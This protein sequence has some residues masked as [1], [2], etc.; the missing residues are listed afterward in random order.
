MAKANEYDAKN[1]IRLKNCLEYL[2]F[3]GKRLSE[4][5]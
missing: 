1:E 4:D 2:I 5:D 3:V